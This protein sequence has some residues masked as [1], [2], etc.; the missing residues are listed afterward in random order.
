M[1]RTGRPAHRHVWRCFF[2]ATKSPAIAR[3]FV[4]IS[5]AQR[6][7]SNG[8]AQLTDTGGGGHIADNKKPRNCE[9]LCR[10]KWCPETD[11]SDGIRFARP[12][13]A[14]RGKARDGFDE[15]NGGAQLTDTGGGGH[16]S[17]NKKPRNC[18]AL[19]RNKWCPEA[20]S[21]HRHADFQSAALP[22]E[23]SGHLV[24]TV[25][26]LSGAY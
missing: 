22:T 23:L 6:R 9:A 15:S 14:R 4:E 3:L 8:G 26:P 18:E 11:K 19:C 1:N 17:D 20:E 10:N 16:I 24:R 5:G 21:N 7:A 25:C 2:Q 13:A 12:Q